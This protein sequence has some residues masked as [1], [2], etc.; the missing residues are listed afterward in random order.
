MKQTVSP[1]IWEGYLILSL[2]SKWNG[3]FGRD[4]S[5]QVLIDKKKRLVITS[6]QCLQ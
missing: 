5:F 3:M 1:C 6:E 2:D 4:L